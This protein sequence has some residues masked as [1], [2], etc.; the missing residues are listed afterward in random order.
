MSSCRA[1]D[2][3]VSRDGFG[4]NDCVGWRPRFHLGGHR[5]RHRL[6]GE[7]GLAC[8][9]RSRRRS[10]T[11]PFLAPCGV[12]CSAST[13]SAASALEAPRLVPRNVRSIVALASVQGSRPACTCS[14]EE[15]F[16]RC[17]IEPA[18]AVLHPCRP[19]DGTQAPEW[20]D[21]TDRQLVRGQETAEITPLTW[22]FGAAPTG[23]EPVSPP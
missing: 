5:F 6:G 3:R 18:I 21:N 9:S 7:P 13:I 2:T 16:P 23:F 12:S 8:S 20:M 11:V 22:V 14:R 1:H 4:G 15:S 17:R 10:S 19:S